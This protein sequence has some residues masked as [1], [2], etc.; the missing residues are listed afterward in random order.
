MKSF[1]TKTLIF[2]V[3]LLILTSGY[4]ISLRE[5]NLPNIYS[6]KNDLLNKDYK[7]I[8]LG[9]SHALRGVIAEDLAYNSINLANVSQS[10]DIDL[11]WLQEA[12]KNDSLKLVILNFSIATLY[13][14]L[15]KSKEN[16]RLR[17]YNIYTGLQVNYLPKYNF[18]LFYGSTQEN[19]DKI[20]HQ[21]NSKHKRNPKYL[22][23]GSFPLNVQMDDFKAHSNAASKRHIVNRN[24]S[25]KNVQ[26]LSDIT[27]LLVQKDVNLLIVTP[28]THKEYRK[29]I[30]AECKA[31][32]FHIISCV[33]IEHKNV[34][35]LNEYETFYDNH[36]FKDSDH[37]NTQGAKKFTEKINNFIY[38]LN[39][40]N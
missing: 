20:T 5:S 3:P 26:F 12:I 22:S 15:D 7:A 19:F 38:K 34:N 21:W 35:W 16:W 25:D 28:P 9:N 14:D 37:L 8:V 33:V 24:I 2:I 23:R 29:L 32:L 10:L 40:T 17:N 11:L 13:G 1:L 6:F 36:N 4:E 18:E 39:L 30:P 27:N 31:E